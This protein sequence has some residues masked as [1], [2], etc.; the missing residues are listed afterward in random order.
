[1]QFGQ[2]IRTPFVRGHVMRDDRGLLRYVPRPSLLGLF[3]LRYRIDPDR[4]R[5]SRLEQSPFLR[6]VC[7]VRQ[8][9]MHACVSMFEGIY[10]SL[11]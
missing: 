7:V 3:Y 6:L 5:Q 2:A 9:H 8:S 10:K 11:L 1:M 4:K